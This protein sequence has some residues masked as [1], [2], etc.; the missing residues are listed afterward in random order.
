[1]ALIDL[2]SKEFIEVF[3]IKSDENGFIAPH[4]SISFPIEFS[5]PI[6]GTFHEEYTIVFEQNHPEVYYFQIVYNFII[7]IFLFISYIFL[8][9]LN[10]LMYLFG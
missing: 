2:V 1:M 9:M 8:L 3:T 7:I 10:H 6:A 5:S 4:S